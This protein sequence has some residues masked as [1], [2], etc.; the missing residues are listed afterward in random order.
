MFGRQLTSQAPS[1]FISLR[2][3]TMKQTRGLPPKLELL[4]A[5]TLKPE[6]WNTP[7][8][9]WMENIKPTHFNKKKGKDVKIE[10]CDLVI[11]FSFICFMVIFARFPSKFLAMATHLA[12]QLTFSAQFLTQPLQFE[13]MRFLQSLELLRFKNAASQRIFAM[14]LKTRKDIWFL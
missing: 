6:A 13:A 5:S 2:L 9:K 11:H 7:S 1:L 10:W 12:V 14:D 3:Q 4:A 8:K